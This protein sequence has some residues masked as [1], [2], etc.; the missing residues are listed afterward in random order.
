MS[1]GGRAVCVPVDELEHKLN[2]LSQT[3]RAV[4]GHVQ[5]RDPKPEALPA[6]V[7]DG[8]KVVSSSQAHAMQTH[9]YGD[10]RHTC[11]SLN[12][13]TSLFKGPTINRADLFYAHP[14]K[15]EKLLATRSLEAITLK[16]I[17]VTGE[18]VVSAPSFIHRSTVAH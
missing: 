13:S 9:T 4:T 5:E 14:H 10:N 18:A 17:F 16:G 6:A 8:L 11:E 7:S 1:T 3:Y 2:T 15:Q 12:Q